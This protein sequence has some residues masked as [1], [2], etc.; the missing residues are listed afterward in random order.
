MDRKMWSE[1]PWTTV[2]VKDPTLADMKKAKAE[3]EKTA[4]HRVTMDEVIR[5]A[6]E[7]F[8]NSI[9]QSEANNAH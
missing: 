4:K 3:I 6:L 2:K 5:M 8:M 9:T 1:I 7:V